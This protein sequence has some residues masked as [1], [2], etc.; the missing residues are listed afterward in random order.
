[1]TEMKGWERLQRLVVSLRGL[2]RFLIVLGHGQVHY[3]L[4]ISA[5]PHVLFVQDLDEKDMAM[6]YRSV[7]YLLSTSRWEGFGLAIAEAL[8]CGV[9]VLLPSQLGVAR[10]LVI[11]GENGLTYSSDDSLLHMIAA[12][13]RLRGGLSD[14]FDWSTNTDKTLALYTRLLQMGVGTGVS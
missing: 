9:P 12:Q 13:P 2:A 5:E 11:E 1:M 10:E 3:P 8:A 4:T 7:S 6:V 14:Q